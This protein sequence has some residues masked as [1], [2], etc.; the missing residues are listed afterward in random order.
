MKRGMKVA[1]VDPQLTWL[2]ARAGKDWLRVRPG[3]DGALAMAMLKVICDEKLYD[4]EFCDKWV[5]GLEASASVS[6][7]M[8]LDELCERAWVDK[9][10][11]CAWPAPTRR[12]IRGHPVGRRPRPANRRA[13][14]A[15]HAITAM[16]CITGN[17]DIL[18]G[19]RHG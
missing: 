5:Y 10:T 8:D 13:S 4:K 12:A 1:V 17:L 19:Q 15:A 14:R 9:E 16:W 6:P 3:G 7:N 2:A 11:S 18:G